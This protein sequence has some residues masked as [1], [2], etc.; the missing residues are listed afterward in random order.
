MYSSLFG[1]LASLF[2]I[3]LLILVELRCFVIG[4][5]SHPSFAVALSTIPPRFEHISATLL[6]WINQEIQ[7]LRICIYVPKSYKRFRRKSKKNITKSFSRLLQSSL[8]LS[9]IVDEWLRNGKIKVVDIDRDWG[10]ITRF[11]GVIQEQR[12]WHAPPNEFSDSCFN[13]FEE[14]IPQYWL[15]CDDDVHYVHNT[16]SKYNY[17][18][19]YFQKQLG[20]VETFGLSQFSEDYRVAYR[21]ESD[22]QQVHLIPHVQGVDTYLI[23]H[24]FLLQQYCAFDVLHYLHVVAAI[25]F[26]HKQC[27]ESFYQDDYIVSFL[28]HLSGLKMISMWNYDK[29]A[30][31]IE[32]V[33]RS[34]FQMHMDEDVFAKEAATKECIS[35]FANYVLLLCSGAPSMLTPIPPVCD[36]HIS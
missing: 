32:G 3:K 7:P 5:N 10:S 29:L 20:L 4:Q 25:E 17:S 31:H 12:Y 8:Q 34:Q 19:S 30:D 9:P 18:I 2:V 22:S 24:N 33:S 16:I 6:S 1:F 13:S 23:P 27:P 14:I 21:L 11:V 26:F 15:F 28:L 36:I 35:I